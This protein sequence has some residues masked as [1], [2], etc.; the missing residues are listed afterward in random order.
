MRFFRQPLLRS[1]RTPPDHAVVARSSAATT[2]TLAALLVLALPSLSAAVERACGSDPAVNV[3]TVLCAPPSGP[4]DAAQVVVSAG[5]EI[6]SSFCLFDLRGRALVIERTIES[7]GRLFFDRCTTLT[8][9]PTGKVK[10]RGDFRQPSDEIDRGGNIEFGCTGLISHHGLL[11]VSGD[12]AGSIELDTDGDI[13]FAAGSLTRGDGLSPG[14]DDGER[15]GDGGFLEGIS[16]DGRIDIRGEISLRGQADGTGGSAN[17]EATQAWALDGDIDVSGGSGGGGDCLVIAGSDASFRGAIDGSSRVGG[18]FGGI[19][20]VQAGDRGPGTITAEDALFDLRGSSADETGGSGGEVLLFAPGTIRLGP[21]TVVRVDAGTQRDGDA[22]S[23]LAEAGSVDGEIEAGEGDI[24]LEGL[25]SARA[26]SGEGTAGAFDIELF[27]GRNLTIAGPIV[28]SGSTFGGT[29]LGE[30]GGA[31]SVSAPLSATASEAEGI[32]GEILL[33]GSQSSNATL[34]ID[35]TLDCS[36]GREGNADTIEISSC[37]IDLRP[38]V[39]IDGRAGTDPDGNAGGADVALAWRHSLEIGD[40][41]RL[42]AGPGG[43]ITL[44][45][46][47]GVFPTIG[48]DV[49]FDPAPIDNP[50]PNLS[51]GL[52]CPDPQCGNGV[53]EPG[54]SCDDGNVDAADDCSPLCEIQCPPEPGPACHELVPGGSGRLLI[55]DESRNNRDLLTWK[56]TR[57]EATTLA[58][59]GDPITRDGYRLCLYDASTEPALLLLSASAPAGGV[60][61]RGACW[62]ANR[63]TGFRYR[64]AARTPEGI[65]RLDLRAGSDRQ[66]KMRA[67]G[68]GPLL[69]LPPLPLPLPARV[70]LHGRAGE[71]WETAFDATGTQHNDTRRFKAR[72]LLPTPRPTPTSATP[73]PT[74]TPTATRTATPL[75]TPDVSTL[76]RLELLPRDVMREMGKM[77]RFTTIGHLADGTLVNL[78]QGV[79][80]RSSDPGV[81]IAT[82]QAGD[83]SRVDTA[84]AG[85]SVISAH[86]AATGVSTTTTGD[87]VTL[88]VFGPLERI[89]L[90]PA[91]STRVAGETLSLSTTGH[92][93]GGGTLDFTHR[94]NYR[95]DDPSVVAAPNTA[96]TK[97]VVTAIAPGTAIISAV[98]PLTGVA[99]TTSGGDA[100]IE[101]ATLER[102]EVLP[103]NTSIEA[104]R[105]MGFS[106]IGH[107]SDGSTRNLTVPSDF[108]TSDPGKV[109]VDA[110]RV[111]GLDPSTVTVTATHLPSGIS[112]TDSG[113]DATLEIRPIAALILSPAESSLA[114]NRGVFITIDAR[115]A[116]GST[117]RLSPNEVVLTSSDPT[118]ATVA[119]GT[120]RA[121][122]RA[123]APG[124]TIIS[125]AAG[126]VTAAE[127]GGALTLT[128]TP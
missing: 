25:V 125:A 89:T 68:K 102:I 24:I 16:A 72:A 70:Q 119:S 98:D 7:K 58:A 38:D 85:T 46:L 61:G 128:V 99:S 113:G 26:G 50:D 54:E 23:F 59:L 112:S 96:G 80:Y 79:E 30:A 71:C 114:V 12:P 118:V 69:V 3:D 127:T 31:I 40:D 5:I 56:W 51:S 8:I 97:H 65:D 101:V 123:I 126:G 91:A 121:S 110:N 57:G 108:A 36:G 11:D 4:C 107:F 39:L 10:A 105:W 62:R 63:N 47:P 88:T 42:L 17:F 29:I 67:T 22:G 64:D 120:F 90:A 1:N 44:T 19:V 117:R 77:I 27:A 55:R 100:T 60:C 124:T 86:H 34:A 14:L 93:V 74:R 78:T 81:G 18:D 115:F 37:S 21:R 111:F 73:T 87:D 2:A 43:A 15:L 92:Y 76:A 106:A 33:F 53:L 109:I 32:G 20:E 103:T 48:D 95:S 41:A 94:V 116:D 75:P 104:L 13:V 83:R 66:A 49:V 28:S 84:A 52:G 9:T 122:A 45:H 35:A 82:N 6:E